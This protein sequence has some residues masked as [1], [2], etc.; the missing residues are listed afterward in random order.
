[1]TTTLA[2]AAENA[3]NATVHRRIT[4]KDGWAARFPRLWCV[5]EQAFCPW[6]VSAGAVVCRRCGRVLIANY[7]DGGD[8]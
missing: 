6:V 4:R 8:G 1:M 7:G 2:R 5:S 3:H